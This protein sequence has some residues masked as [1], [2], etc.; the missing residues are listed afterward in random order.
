MDCQ[1]FGAGIY[2]CLKIGPLAMAVLEW[3]TIEAVSNKC[4]LPD[5]KNILDE[6]IDEKWRVIYENQ[7]N[8]NNIYLFQLKIGGKKSLRLLEVP[9]E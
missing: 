7:L 1:Y 5:T 8:M 3:T 6:F 4:N 2:L 9:P